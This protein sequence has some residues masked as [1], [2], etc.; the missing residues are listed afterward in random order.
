M[1]SILIQ[2]E[3]EM[4]LGGPLNNLIEMMEHSVIDDICRVVS[5]NVF[6]FLLM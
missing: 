1:W 5:S 2:E 3:E 6:F 4:G